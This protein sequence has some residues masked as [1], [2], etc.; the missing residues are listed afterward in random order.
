MTPVRLHAL[1]SLSLSLSL[2]LYRLRGAVRRG[3]RGRAT[4]ISHSDRIRGT[5]AVERRERPTCSRDET[6][7]ALYGRQPSLASDGPALVELGRESKLGGSISDVR[8]Q[9]I[10]RETN[11]IESEGL[12]SARPFVDFEAYTRPLLWK[13]EEAPQG[14]I[15]V[16]SLKV[17]FKSA[18]D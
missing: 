17:W 12:P 7:K 3:G 16:F 5:K 14:S 9:T 6:V 13:S 4:L 1:L 2:S 10:A 18:I 11:V 15:F 8:F